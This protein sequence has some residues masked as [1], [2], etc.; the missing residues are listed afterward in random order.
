MEICGILDGRRGGWS[1]LQQFE[2][3]KIQTCEDVISKYR[4]RANMFS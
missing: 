4:R 3:V 1:G 2:V